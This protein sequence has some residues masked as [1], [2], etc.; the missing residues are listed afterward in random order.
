[1]NDLLGVIDYGGINYGE[2]YR[3]FRRRNMFIYLGIGH[4]LNAQTALFFKTGYT[5]DYIH[6]EIELGEGVFSTFFAFGKKAV[7][8]R[9]GLTYKLF[10]KKF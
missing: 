1:M 10:S 8:F 3:R 4:S 6:D 9:F 2:L 5:P 7:E